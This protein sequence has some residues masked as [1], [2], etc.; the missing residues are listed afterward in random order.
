MEV[1]TMLV[2]TAED[3]RRLAPLAS[4]IGELR[5]A[6]RGD[7]FVP[8]R[9]VMTIPGGRNSRALLSMPAFNMDGSGAVKL[10]SVFPDNREIGRP[11]IQSTIVVFSAQGQPVALL[12]G[13]MTTKLRTAAASALASTY[14]SRIDSAHLL[15]VGTGA[16]A[17]VMAAGHCAVRGIER[18][19]VWG[20]NRAHADETVSA[21]KTLVGR[22]VHA[23]FTESLEA[24]VGQAD[25]V[26]CATS[27]SSPLIQGRWLKNGVHVDL[28]GS[29]SPPN[30]ESD[31]DVVLRSRIFVDTV[32]GALAEAGDIIDPMR[33]HIIE[34][35]HIEGELA[36]LVQERVPG[37]T[38]PNQITLFKSVGTAI[39]DLAAAQMIVQRAVSGGG[40]FDRKCDEVLGSE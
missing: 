13:T 28:V 12:D 14:L 2:L 10:A 21:V 1:S 19:S 3:V 5:R 17:P 34:R 8:A 11:T 23:A 33:R 40:R 29:F 22:Q 4:L 16:L 38:D 36:D 26:C 25:I 30:R 39:A 32:D 35:R 7:Y 24:A 9:Q 6:F 27:A 37:R 15:L 20:R 31:D 18:I